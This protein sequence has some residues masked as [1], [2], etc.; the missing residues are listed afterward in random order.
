MDHFLQAYSHAFLYILSGKRQLHASQY[1]C[2]DFE[3]ELLPDRRQGLSRWCGG[4][5]AW[6]ELKDLGS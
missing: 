4:R 3:T 2:P 6:G 1:Q 5:Y